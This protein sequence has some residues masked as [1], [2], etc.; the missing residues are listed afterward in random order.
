M[1]DWPS[2]SPLTAIGRSRGGGSGGGAETSSASAPTTFT[3]IVTGWARPSVRTASRP[4]EERAPS[5]ACSVSRRPPGPSLDS[6]ASA[7]VCQA[8][9]NRTSSKVMPTGSQAWQ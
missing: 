1:R 7:S 3:P 8:V 9:S 4:R 2:S 5:S 6:V